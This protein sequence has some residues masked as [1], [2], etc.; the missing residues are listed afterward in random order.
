MGERGVALVRE[1]YGVDV[2]APR[3]AALLKDVAGAGT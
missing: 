2:V 3:L 1:H